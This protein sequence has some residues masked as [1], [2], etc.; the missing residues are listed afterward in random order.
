V[1]LG[2]ADAS[3]HLIEFADF[4]CP[5]CAS[6]HTTLKAVR[7]RYPSQVTLSFVH[8]PLPGHRFAEPAARAAECAGEQGKFESMHDLLFERQAA[9]GMKPWEEFAA[10]AGIPD[11]GAFQSCMSSMEPVARIVAGRKLAEQLNVAGTPT[12]IVNG[13]KLTSLPRDA[14][15]DQ[16]IKA[17]LAGKDPFAKS[18]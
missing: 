4:E 5:Y 2:P 16:I 18:K 6:Y 13:W 12:L 10:E 7:N 17:L 15:F 3:V 11:H 14:E 9:F 1:Q 8:Y